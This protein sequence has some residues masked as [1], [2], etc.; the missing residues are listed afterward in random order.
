MDDCNTRHLYSWLG[1]SESELRLAVIALL[2][3]SLVQDCYNQPVLEKFR[4]FTSPKKYVQDRYESQPAEIIGAL[5][6]F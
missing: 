1:G 3:H 4:K 6:C 5:S 2:L